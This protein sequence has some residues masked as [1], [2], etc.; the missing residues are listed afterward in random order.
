[1]L[2]AIKGDFIREILTRI[3]REKAK[4]Q[5]GGEI[6]EGSVMFMDKAEGESN[7]SSF[8]DNFYRRYI[9]QYETRY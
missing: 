7:C 2:K 9:G 4:A 8:I 1:M 3:L 5:S 6:H